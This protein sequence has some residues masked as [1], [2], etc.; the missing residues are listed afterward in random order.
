[1]E[2]YYISFSSL[3]WRSNN[4]TTTNETLIGINNSRYT[5]LDEAKL[6][7]NKAFVLIHDSS[8]EGMIITHSLKKDNGHI[9]FLKT[10]EDVIQLSIKINRTGSL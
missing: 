9:L 8:Y 1:M 2:L 4:A 5:T 7:L 10:C 3:L 6:A